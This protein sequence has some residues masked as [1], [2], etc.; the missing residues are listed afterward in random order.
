M[1]E[2]W[3]GYWSRI[4]HCFTSIAGW[5]HAG[6][7]GIQPDPAVPG[8]RKII[9]RPAIVEDLE[10][11]RCSHRCNYG[12]I[13]S[14]WQRNGER[15][16]M[17]IVI[18]PNTSATVYLPSTDPRKAT[19]SGIALTEVPSLRLM[20]HEAGHTVVE[21][22]SGRYF[23]T[24]TVAFP[25]KANFVEVLENG[26]ASTLVFYGTSLTA[27]PWSAWV[28]MLE[29][30]LHTRFPGQ[31]AIHNQATGCMASNFGLQN[32]HEKVLHLNPDVVFIE[33]AI[34]DAWKGSGI[35]SAEEAKANWEEMI[36]RILLKNADCE[37]IL[38]LMN[39]PVNGMQER[40]NYEGYCRMVR[41]LAHERGLRLIDHTPV[42]REIETD[43]VLK[44]RY[45]PDNIHPN[46]TASREV[47]LPVILKGLGV[48]M[49]T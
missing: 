42:W 24:S 41:S 22:G 49:E 17:E 36:K 8:F 29:R 44:H 12:T 43:T 34:N 10:W 9:I 5:F 11:V 26:N 13:V 38:M 4:H 33:Y 21:I 7:A 30:E 27:E 14:N 25:R 16:E 19:E 31:S 48:A 1:W 46:V 37:I 45:I 40:V 20:G 6:L 28:P 47:T 2:Q 23:F 3:N 18:P 35:S 15:L 32:L 39:P